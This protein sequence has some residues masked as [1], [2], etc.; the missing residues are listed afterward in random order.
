MIESMPTFY[1]LFG[2]FNGEKRSRHA[3]AMSKNG[4]T[5]AV[6][7][8]FPDFDIREIKK[9]LIKLD[10]HPYIEDENQSELQG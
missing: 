1:T 3:V 6:L 10:S 8:K 2:F 4:A 7:K 9:G 5:D